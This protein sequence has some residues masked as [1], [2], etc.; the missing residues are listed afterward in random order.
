MNEEL[1]TIKADESN[2]NENGTILM[3]GDLTISNIEGVKEQVLTAMNDFTNITV[4]LNDVENMDLSFVQ[5][6]YSISKTAKSRNSK[7]QFDINLSET[8]QTLLNH[9][10]F[11]DLQF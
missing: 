5:L 7:I 4:K 2:S 3:Q 1:V 9:S 8:I 6:L 10:G 11:K